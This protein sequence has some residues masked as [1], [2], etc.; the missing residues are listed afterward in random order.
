[1]RIQINH[2]SVCHE[3]NL[4]GIAQL[5]GLNIREKTYIFDSLEKYFS[6]SKYAE[7][8][9][10]MSDNV[11]VQNEQVGR[12]YIS[13]IR[14]KSREEL[15]S[16]L[17][18]SK[19]GLFLEYLKSNVNSFENQKIFEEVVNKAETLAISLNTQ[20]E[21]EIGNMQV[22]FDWNSLLEILAKMNVFAADFRALEVLNN[23]ELMKNYLNLIS[24]MQKRV[25]EKRL[26]IFENI[27]HLLSYDE[28]LQAYSKMED[29][30]RKSDIAFLTSTSLAQFAHITKDNME[31]I[32]VLNE[33]L[34]QLPSFEKWEEFI[35][36]K[37]P[38]YL[39]E[40]IGVEVLRGRIQ[41]LGEKL[42]ILNPKADVIYK[43]IGESMGI[44]MKFIG[45]LSL[46]EASY[47]QESVV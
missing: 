6:K 28:F 27:D 11:F 36:K 5:C 29:M 2:G 38:C 12:N 45:K 16:S 44:P 26:I 40:G 3:L 46:P 7:F 19:T 47:L 9:K 41:E 33:E 24:E 43:M 17:K 14:I 1:M 15:L 32:H 10:D 4:D 30:I 21:A 39:E 25:P 31:S 23:A 20:I 13:V 35:G 8:E 42:D 18:I 37:Y 34:Y 22:G